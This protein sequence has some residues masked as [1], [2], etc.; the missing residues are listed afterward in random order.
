MKKIDEFI[1]TPNLSSFL[2]IN[3]TNLENL[4]TKYSE[5]PQEKNCDTLR[6]NFNKNIV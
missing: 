3:N 2:F 4:L 5:E 6:N 1:S